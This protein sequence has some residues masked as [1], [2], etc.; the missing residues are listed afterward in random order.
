MTLLELS[1]PSWGPVRTKVILRSSK[2]TNTADVFAAGTSVAFSLSSRSSYQQWSLGRWRMFWTCHHSL[3]ERPRGDPCGMACSWR[4]DSVT[5]ILTGRTCFLFST[6]AYAQELRFL[7][8]CSKYSSPG[9][10]RTASLCDDNKIAMLQQ[11]PISLHQFLHFNRAQ[12][13]LAQNTYLSWAV[14]NDVKRNSILRSRNSKNWNFRHPPSPLGR[15][16]RP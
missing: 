2:I 6:V 1:R 11:D 4:I 13:P 16:Y 10:T 3:H 5:S 7:P 14:S 15:W 12:R 8:A 9:Y